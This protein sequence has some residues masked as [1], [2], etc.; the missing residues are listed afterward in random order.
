M[1]GMWKMEKC[2]VNYEFVNFDMI[3]DIIVLY[4]GEL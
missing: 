2:G 4:N 3:I 1:V